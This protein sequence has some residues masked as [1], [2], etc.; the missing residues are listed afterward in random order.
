MSHRFALPSV[1]RFALAFGS[2]AAAALVSTGCAPDLARDAGDD[3]VAVPDLVTD[4]DDEAAVRAQLQQR[5]LRPFLRPRPIVLEVPWEHARA[6][7]GKDTL[8]GEDHDDRD[9]AFAGP[10][11]PPLKIF[12]NRNGGTYSPG[13]DDSRRNTSIVPTR[14]SQIGAFPYSDTAWNSLVDCVTDQFARFNVQ[15]VETEPPSNERY[16][17]HVVGGRPG[18]V[19]LPNG[20][21]GVAPIDN[22]NCSVIDIAINY[23]FAAVYGDV[24]SICETAAQE[25]AHSFSLD[26]ELFCPDPMTYLGGCGAKTFQDS[27]QPCGEFQARS[28]NCNRPSQNSVQIMLQKLGPADGSNPVEPPPEDPTP[29]TV[30]ITSPSDGAG[31]LQDSTITITANATDNVAIAATELV[32]DFSGD[33]FGCPTTVGGGALTCTRTGNVST[34]SVRVGQGQRTFSVRARDT[35]GN[36]SET[37]KRTITLS[38][39]GTAPPPP[40]STDTTAP[41]ANIAAPADGAVLAANST[42]QVVANVSDDVALASVELLWRATGDV[43]PCPFSGQAVTCEQSGTT[44]TWTLNVGVGLR[45]FAVRAIDTAGQTTTTAERTIELSTDDVPVNPGDPDTVGEP[46]DDANTAFPIRCGSA[47]DLV[48]ASDNEDWFAIDAPADTAVELGIAVTGS[49]TVGLSLLTATGADVLASTDDIVAEGGALRAVSA[50]PAV[51]ARVR[52]AA[53]AVGYR[54]TATCSQEGGDAP[55][56]GTD[57]DLEDNDDATTP[58]RAFCGEQK[59]SLIAADDDFFIVE[60]R[61]GDA[62]QVVLTSGGAQASVVDG[63]GVVLAGPGADVTAANLTAGDYLV[64]IAPTLDPAYYDVA[65]ECG[66][67]PPAAATGCGCSSDGGAPASALA[68]LFVLLRRRRRAARQG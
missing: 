32:W 12:L 11:Q 15:I 9:L 45:P 42:M 35:A 47:I 38:A 22:F 17:E 60:A 58:T 21:G 61:Q 66:A 29:P 26:H 23:T 24:Q 16:V 50:G 37:S 1:V 13:Q 10:G 65:F 3:G 53:G 67:S 2:A 36:V 14:V 33:T 43:F 25:I 31:L 55:P 28:C 27:N 6:S 49:G 48:V 59:T 20:V 8:V 41:S 5:G 40:P 51:L 62:L 4:V 46:N 30:T 54:L 68:I 64:K 18:D 52:T 7:G 57:D 39:D 63:A 44:F 56:P 19:G 34:W